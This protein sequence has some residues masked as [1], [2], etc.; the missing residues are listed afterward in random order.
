[1]PLYE[2]TVPSRYT[3]LLIDYIRSGQS[4]WPQAQ[5]LLPDLADCTDAMPIGQY[6]ALWQTARRLSGRADVGFEVGWR[7]TSASHGLMSQAFFS[8]AS[9]D[10]ALRLAA[11][12]SWLFTPSF[13]LHYRRQ[14]A[15][16]EL[17]LRPAAGM[18]VET[19]HGF[20]EVH[21]V[22]AFLL[23]RDVLGA[24]LQ[25]Y[26][27][28]LPMRRPAYAARYRELRPARVH[29][30]PAG[31]PEVRTVLSGA[32]LDLPLAPAPDAPL[33]ALRDAP[34]PGITGNWR[35]W[36]QLMLRE[37]EDCQP[38]QAQLAELLGMSA[39]TLARRLAAEGCSFRQL[40][41]EV[42]HA[43]ACRM[44][45]EGQLSISQ[46]ASRLGYN[47]HANFSHAFRRMAGVSAATYRTRRPC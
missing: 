24:R 12:Y 43:R 5:G 22:S 17:I 6:D 44:L 16:G 41:A 10:E 29:F 9:L 8:S 35:A 23:L 30:E 33:L 13:A 26:D 45:D 42:R 20:Y 36:V 21:A 34:R 4:A 2:A 18:S 25:A 37:A 19:L 39:H 1:M 32:V 28:H 38:T 40:A 3:Q 31:L 14:P 15:Y 11:R 7:V 47:D 46:I 27:I